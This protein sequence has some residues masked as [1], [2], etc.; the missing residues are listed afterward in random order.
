MSGGF[1]YEFYVSK[2][3]VPSALT[4]HNL[5]SW[6]KAFFILDNSPQLKF[7]TQQEE[8]VVSCFSGK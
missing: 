4:L 6:N 2:I 7:V 3:W 1:E 5:N 8:K